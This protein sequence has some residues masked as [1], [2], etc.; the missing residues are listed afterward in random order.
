MC[1]ETGKCGPHTGRKRQQKLPVRGSRDVTCR[2]QRLQSSHFKCAQTCQKKK[3][4]D[5]VS[6]NREYQERDKKDF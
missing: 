6:T 2:G 4:D 3:Y 1:K 5:N